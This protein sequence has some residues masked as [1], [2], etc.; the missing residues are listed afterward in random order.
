MLILRDQ[1]CLLI[2]SFSTHLIP[3]VRQAFEK[4]AVAKAPCPQESKMTKVKER[5]G[6]K[7]R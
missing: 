5:T 6:K 4:K 3:E 2:S 7:Q 1:F